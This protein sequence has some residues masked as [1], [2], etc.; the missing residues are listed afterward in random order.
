MSDENLVS[1]PKTFHDFLYNQLTRRG[2]DLSD[3]EI[4][5]IIESYELA[6]KEVEG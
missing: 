2:W 1:N 6:K 5:C 4:D 3:T